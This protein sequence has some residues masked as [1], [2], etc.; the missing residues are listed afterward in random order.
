MVVSGHWGRTGEAAHRGQRPHTRGA[1][2]AAG[3][4]PRS[5]V[6]RIVPGLRLLACPR[7]PGSWAGSCAP[8]VLE[9]RIVPGVG[10][11]SGPPS[12]RCPPPTGQLAAAAARAPPLRKAGQTEPCPVPRPAWTAASGC[13]HHLTC[14]LLRAASRCERKR[15]EAN[16]RQVRRRRTPDSPWPW[17]WPW[18][19]VCG[20]QTCFTPPRTSGRATR[21]AKERWA[22]A[23]LRCYGARGL[24]A[25]S[26]WRPE[27]V[28]SKVMHN[29]QMG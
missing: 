17:P 12:H 2:G 21:L 22:R 25:G 28:G 3:G 24:W 20:S 29:A 8:P 18:P 14:W 15:E 9:K 6:L 23:G 16:S 5:P 19:P 13:Q 4:R 11:R 27:I 10:R 1:P 26:F 7:W